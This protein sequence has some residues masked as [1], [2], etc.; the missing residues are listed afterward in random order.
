[1]I[2]FIYKRGDELH[3]YLYAIALK[4]K[5][6]EQFLHERKKN[7]FSVVEKNLSN[8]EI[9]GIKTKY[10]KY[11]LRRRGFETSSSSSFTGYDTIYLVTT[12]YEEMDVFVNSDKVLANISRYTLEETRY[13]K[14]DIIKALHKLHYF[15][16]QKWGQTNELGIS[17]YFMS[18]IHEMNFNDYKVDNFG[19]FMFLYGETIDKETLI[20]GK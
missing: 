20:N 3:P 11:I 1:M 6:M 12:E 19:I 17:D 15:E 9:N 16:I 18:G 5:L 4:K 2:Y 8:E 10:Q 13:M 7:I 14:K